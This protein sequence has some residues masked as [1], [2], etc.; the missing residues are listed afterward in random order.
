MINKMVTKQ[1]K[2]KIAIFGCSWS[3]GLWQKNYDS[4][5]KEF[6][7]LS[8]DCEIYNFAMAGSSLSYAAHL[9]E[10]VYDSDLKFDLKIF[11]ATSPG[12]FTW[13]DN[14]N[15]LDFLKQ[16]ADNLFSVDD[17]KISKVV[18]KINY[19]TVYAKNHLLKKD[20]KFGI[21]YYSK[22]NLELSA[23]EYRALLEFV[24]RR[25]DLLF[26]HRSMKDYNLNYLSVYDELG[27]SN[28]KKFTID[29]GEHFSN[30]GNKWEA[31]WVLNK[32]NQNKFL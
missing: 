18:H 3:Q 4:W 15:I 13:W 12:R 8:P 22:L 7:K 26:A 6:S 9:L 19:G 25:V 31:N 30:A 27:N 28:F 5:V 10:Q 29:E 20:K 23:L 1:F 21:D 14:H 2:T 11:Q 17:S 16:D 32:L 24:D